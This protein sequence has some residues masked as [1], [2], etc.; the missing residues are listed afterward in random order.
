MG[1]EEGERVRNGCAMSKRDPVLAG[2]VVSSSVSHGFRDG[3]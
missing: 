3:H 2:W 1:K